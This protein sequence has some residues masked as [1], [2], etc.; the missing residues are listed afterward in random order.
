[1]QVVLSIQAG[2]VLPSMLLRKLGSRSKKNRLYQA[3]RVVC[4]GIWDPHPTVIGTGKPR[5]ILWI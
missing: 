2:K 5:K 3:F 4:R 1:M